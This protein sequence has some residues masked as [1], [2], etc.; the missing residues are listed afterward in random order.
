MD[1]IM[2]VLLGIIAFTSL[3]V[4]I[5]MV[6]KAKR[7]SEDMRI[8]RDTL[9]RGDMVRVKGMEGK[10]EVWKAHVDAVT[11]IRFNGRKISYSC[12]RKDDVYPLLNE[13]EYEI[14]HE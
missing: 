13:V 4:L 1:R 9:Q 3:V 12:V 5:T 10:Q 8:W 11:L 7:E 6:N 2:F 14:V